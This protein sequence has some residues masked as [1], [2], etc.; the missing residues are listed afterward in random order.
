MLVLLL[1]LLQGVIWVCHAGAECKSLVTYS[2]CRAG[3]NKKFDIVKPVV[4]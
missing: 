1:T 2:G 3:K 4:K